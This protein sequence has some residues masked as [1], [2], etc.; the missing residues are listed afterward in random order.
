MA[1]DIAER[2]KGWERQVCFLVTA[3][4]LSQELTCVS[5]A[6]LKLWKA[7]AT[8]IRTLLQSGSR[9]CAPYPSTRLQLD[10]WFYS[11]CLARNLTT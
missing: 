10:L 8:A 1:P 2:E 5:H 9:E 3:Y 7:E 6:G 11:Y 4:G